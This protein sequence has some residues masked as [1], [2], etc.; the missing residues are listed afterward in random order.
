M[1]P[2]FESA[3][4][5]MGD[6]ASVAGTATSTSDDST[7]NLPPARV[8]DPVG[9]TRSRMMESLTQS[10]HVLLASAHRTNIE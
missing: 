2:S 4:V 8:I 1:D 3:T 5:V 10:V 6:Q 9:A 7:V